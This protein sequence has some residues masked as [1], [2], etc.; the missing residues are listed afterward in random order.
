MEKK[1]VSLLTVILN[2]LCAVLWTINCLMK[3]GEGEVRVLD[4]LCA[5]AWTF[6]AVVWTVRYRKYKKSE[7]ADES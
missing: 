1:P 5:I 6:T 3:L 4:V 7:T 2:C